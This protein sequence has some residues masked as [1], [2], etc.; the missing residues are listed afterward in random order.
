MFAWVLFL[1]SEGRR[2]SW[3]AAAPVHAADLVLE[4][5]CS[6]AVWLVSVPWLMSC[7]T[8]WNL[9]SRWHPHSDQ[10]TVSKCFLTKMPPAPLSCCYQ[11]AAVPNMWMTAV[12]RV[13]I[14]RL[15]TADGRSRW[16]VSRSCSA[17][18]L[19]RSV[20]LR[21]C[22][23]CSRACGREDHVTHDN[24]HR[25]AAEESTNVTEAGDVTTPA[26]TWPQG[27]HR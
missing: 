3:E 21:E 7:G 27:R 19:L 20:Q 6:T 17:V 8:G 15:F 11:T 10:S 2:R 5:K 25:H 13:T 1:G 26:R 18:F 22:E 23:I 12:R 16:H 24:H 9:A 4:L 14:T